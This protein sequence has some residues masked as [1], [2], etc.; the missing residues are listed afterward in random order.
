MQYVPLWTTILRSRKIFNLDDSAFRFWINCLALAQ[1]HDQRRGSLPDLDSIAFSLRLDDDVASSLMDRLTAAGLIDVVGTEHV[2]HNWDKWRY[3]ADPTAAE[4]KRNQRMRQKSDVTDV[5][6]QRDSHACHESHAIQNSTEAEQ[7]RDRT[8]G[9]CAPPA[10]ARPRTHEAPPEV[11]P[12]APKPEPEW[13]PQPLPDES[14]TGRSGRD[15]ADFVRAVQILDSHHSTRRLGAELRMHCDTP[16]VRMLQGW[17]F[18]C[19]AF[20]VQR[21]DRNRSWGALTGFARASTQAEFDKLNSQAPARASP[22]ASLPVKTDEEL[23]AQTDEGNRKVAA[24]R[25][26][27]GL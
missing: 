22:A 17:Q 18:V 7:D 6:G 16:G 20:N 10:H 11:I 21:P 14:M 8:E 27:M 25:K 4:R 12:L 24:Y 26:R 1:D 5:T 19:G 15:H 2:I 9:A 13:E 23:R 3:R